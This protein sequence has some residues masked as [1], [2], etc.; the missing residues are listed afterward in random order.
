[1]V[2]CKYNP[3]ILNLNDLLAQRILSFIGSKDINGNTALIHLFMSAK[4]NYVKFNS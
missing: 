2:I 4:L 1:M 3:Q